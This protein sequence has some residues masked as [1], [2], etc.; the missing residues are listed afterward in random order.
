MWCWCSASELSVAFNDACDPI[1]V[2]AV[3]GVAHLGGVC[4]IPQPSMQGRAPP[5][6]LLEQGFMLLLAPQRQAGCVIQ[7]VV[8]SPRRWEMKT[9]FVALPLSIAAEFCGIVFLSGK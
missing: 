6:T 7:R 5:R 9:L 3:Y 8:F 1:A 2:K 4:S